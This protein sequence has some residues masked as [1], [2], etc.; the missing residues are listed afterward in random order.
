MAL[1]K[2]NVVGTNF[3]LITIER[4][5]SLHCIWYLFMLIKTDRKQK[6]KQWRK[7][8]ERREWV[9]LIESIFKWSDRASWFG[10]VYYKDTQFYHPLILFARFLILVG[11]M[12]SIG[13]QRFSVVML[14]ELS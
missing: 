10:I 7:G 11:I 9:S 6:R 13:F 8:V 1:R 2:E 4:I 14:F 3:F 12:N 5:N